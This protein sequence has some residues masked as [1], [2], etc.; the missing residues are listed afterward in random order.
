MLK[1]QRLLFLCTE[2]NSY[3]HFTALGFAC[4]L[5][6]IFI[7]I[8]FPSLTIGCTRMAARSTLAQFV[9]DQNFRANSDEIQANNL[10]SPFSTNYC[11]INCDQRC[12][13]NK[14]TPFH[15]C[16]QENE[17][18]KSCAL[19]LFLQVRTCSHKAMMA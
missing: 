9:L 13:V 2:T 10:T 12:R 15:V 8:L 17:H 11:S 7:W 1:Q 19:L 18:V 4:F 5:L 3:L 6:D 16:R 14:M